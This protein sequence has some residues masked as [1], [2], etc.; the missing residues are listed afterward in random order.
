MDSCNKWLEMDNF[1]P[2]VRFITPM[3]HLRVLGLRELL[4][5]SFVGT[6]LSSGYCCHG[7]HI[8]WSGANPTAMLV[9]T[10]QC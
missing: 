4:E 5:Q 9:S 10:L 1:S 3:F 8:V 2:S 6:R 7:S